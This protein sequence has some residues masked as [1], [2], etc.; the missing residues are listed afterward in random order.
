[1]KKNDKCEK[2]P[3]MTDKQIERTLILLKFDSQ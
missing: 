3:N 1:M 2:L